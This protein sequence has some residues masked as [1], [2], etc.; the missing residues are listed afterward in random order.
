LDAHPYSLGQIL[1]LDR[2]FVIPTFQR[3]YEWTRDGQWELLFQ[4]L[5]QVAGRLQLAR[6]R[7]AAEGLD[8][9]SADKS[10]GAH[11][12]G[13]LVLDQ[14]PAPAGSLDVRAVVDGQQRLTT[15]E[16]LIRGLVDAIRACELKPIPKL[17]RL[18]VNHEDVGSSDER[19]KLWPRQRDREVWRSAMSEEPSPANRHIY[20]E[21]RRFFA[22]RAQSVIKNASDPANTASVIADALFGLFKVVVIDLGDTDDA[23]VI[24]EVLNGRQTALSPADLVKNLL[25]LRAKG[26]NEAELETL[27]ETY[28]ARFDDPWWKKE[29]GRGHA[30]RRNSDAMLSAWVTAAQGSEIVASRLYSEI[31]NYLGRSGR[32]IPDVLREI[33]DYADHY[34]VVNGLK[35]EPDERVRAAYHRLGVLGVTTAMP[36]LLWLRAQLDEGLK[37]DDHAASVLAVESFVIRRVLVGAQ[38]RGYGVAFANV[39]SKV[40]Q[41]AKAGGPVADAVETELRNRPNGA[42]WPSDEEIASEFVS[43]R[44]YG[45]DSQQRLRLILGALDEHLRKLNRKAEPAAFD[46]DVLTVEHVMPIAWRNHW[47]VGDGSDAERLVAEQD[48]DLVVNRIGN[49]TLVTQALNPNLSNGPWLTKR[50]AIKLNSSLVLNARIVESETWS[51]VEIAARAREL[52][53]TACAVWSRPAVESADELESTGAERIRSGSD[54]VLWTRIDAAT[55]AIP[56]GYWTS[57]GDLAEL[58]GTAPQVVGNH[59]ANETSVVNGYRVLDRGGRIVAAFRWSDPA[60]TRNPRAVLEGEGLHFDDAGRADSA[61]RLD[62]YQLAQR[63]PELFTEEEIS[64]LAERHDAAPSDA[65]TGELA[66]RHKLRRRFWT[67]LLERAQTKTKLHKAVSPSTWNWI[68]AGAGMSGVSFNYVVS[69]H[70]GRVELYIDRHSREENKELFHQLLDKRADIERLAEMELEWDQL[71]GRKACRIARTVPGGGYGNEEQDWPGIQEQLVDAMLRLETGMR[72]SIDQLKG[73]AWR[74]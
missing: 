41:A 46:Y 10:V 20:L 19:Y 34:Q 8:Q 51:E 53:K 14:L 11:F 3:D 47:P 67:G 2:R 21:A 40:Q 63:I 25:F 1:T 68:A 5:E 42:H 12:L 31:R 28:W 60:D 45:V 7:A 71:E 44:F 13:A 35:P 74:S 52:A 39:L 59:V 58:V 4:D 9:S 54:R 32:T 64:Q 29:I 70:G 43:R 66:E 61:G 23:Q 62:A 6:Q 18:L 30:A 73:G 65:P 27:Y 48:R 22:E 16:L 33:A 24:F 50:A 72:P 38:T 56:A 17:H 49:L 37:P 55:A 15:L 69:R 36:L 26:L 57:Y